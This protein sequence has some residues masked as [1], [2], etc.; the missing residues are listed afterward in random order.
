MMTYKGIEVDLIDDETGREL[1]PGR[2]YLI[3]SSP[4]MIRSGGD[5]YYLS[6]RPGRTNM[7]HEPK[8]HGWLGTTNDIAAYAQGAVEL[9][10]NKGGH[11]RL[12]KI[13][14]ASV[15]EEIGA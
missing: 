2:Y 7:S 6:R 15:D 12:R 4:T 14:P 10:Q 8:V 9:Y 1:E 13:E 5:S 3:L 11:L